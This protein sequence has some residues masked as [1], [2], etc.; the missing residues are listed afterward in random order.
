MKYPR[1]SEHTAVQ[2][3]YERMRRRGQ[4]HNMAEMLSLRRIPACRTNATLLA[5]VNG[6][7]DEFTFEDNGMH[8]KAV[9]KAA[10][11]VGV[12]PRQYQPQ[13][14]DFAGDPKAFLPNDDPRGHLKKLE[15]R[16][17]E[18]TAKLTEQSDE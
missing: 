9:L 10:N 11:R 4:S 17:K 3:A 15:R 6:A 8:S 16:Q 18:K 7:K 5:A 13:L 14:A 1:I 12:H 2:R